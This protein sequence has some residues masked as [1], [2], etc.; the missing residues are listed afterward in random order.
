MAF[1]SEKYHYNEL[2]SCEM[3]R[4]VNLT[5]SKRRSALGKGDFNLD[6]LTITADSTVANAIMTM[7]ILQ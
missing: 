6:T 5:L 2:F 7:F 4:F 3:K 1:F